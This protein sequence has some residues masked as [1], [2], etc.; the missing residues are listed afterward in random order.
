[1]D[2]CLK[3]LIYAPVLV[4]LLAACSL[5]NKNDID[6][7]AITKEKSSAGY[8]YGSYIYEQ[9]TPV[10]LGRDMGY[11]SILVNPVGGSD[12]KP[13]Y[14]KFEDRGFFLYSL[15]PGIYEISGLYAQIL[16]STMSIK[17]FTNCTFTVKDGE[18]SYLGKFS[19]Y[20]VCNPS[21]QVIVS[22]GPSRSKSDKDRS[23]LSQKNASVNDLP[24]TA[25]TVDVSVPKQVYYTVEPGSGGGM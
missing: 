1:M 17:H 18:I 24:F 10:L 20:F 11:L 6:P 3:Q 19:L 16:D 12:Q 8:V 4:I 7:S 13:F 9:R 22:A 14:I 21:F 15:K 2:G 23:F 25:Y 5:A